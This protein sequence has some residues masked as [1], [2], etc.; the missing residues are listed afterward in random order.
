MIE[1]LG[2]ITKKAELLETNFLQE[3]GVDTLGKYPEIESHISKMIDTLVGEDAELV[4]VDESYV[5][6]IEA[7]LDDKEN[8]LFA[9]GCDLSDMKKVIDKMQ[10]S[11]LKTILLSYIKNMMNNL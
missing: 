9:I 5:A 2:E 7:D 3:M 6:E 8:A 1:T 10:E 4:E 11:E